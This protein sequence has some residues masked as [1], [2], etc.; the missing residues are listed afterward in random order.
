MPPELR[1]R[2]FGAFFLWVSVSRGG[3][4][5]S[6]VTASAGRGCCLSGVLVKGLSVRVSVRAG[7]ITRRP[8]SRGVLSCGRSVVGV[9]VLFLVGGCP[10]ARVAVCHTPAAVAVSVAIAAALMGEIAQATRSRFRFAGVR[11]GLSMG[12]GF[13]GKGLLTSRRRYALVKV[14]PAAHGGRLRLWHPRFASGVCLRCSPVSGRGLS[15]HGR[16]VIVGGRSVRF[17]VSVCVPS[18]ASCHGK[19]TTARRGLPFTVC[20]SPCSGG[21]W[22]PSLCG[23]RCRLSGFCWVNQ[24]PTVAPPWVGWAVAIACAQGHRNRMN[25]DC[26]QEFS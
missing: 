10:W 21:C 3:L 20:G 1:R 24:P 19:T 6:P 23:H 17:P 9:V 14:L 26:K 8:S 7:L 11:F 22:L 16:R 4:S 18:V 2:G 13:R 15:H 5:P 12:L 25:K